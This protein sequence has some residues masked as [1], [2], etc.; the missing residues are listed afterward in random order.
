MLPSAFILLAF[1]WAPLVSATPVGSPIHVPITRR[2]PQLSRRDGGEVNPL[3]R[4]VKAADFVRLK[5]GFDPLSSK[6][7][8]QNTA[9]VPIIDQNSDSSYLG[10]I[11]IGTPAQTFNVILDTGS[12]DFWLAST[13]CSTCPSG[14]PEYSSSKSS[15]STLSTT[16]VSIKYGSGAVAGTLTQDAL[17]MGGFLVSQQQFVSVTQVSSQFLTGTAAGLMGLGWQT[18]ASSGAMPFWQALFNANQFTTPEFS[19]YLRRLVDDPSAP[20]ETYGGEFTLGGTNSSLY[21]G[22]IEFLNFP[23]GVTPSFWVLPVTGL[24]V[25]GKA[26]T[27][28][29]GNSALAA[30]DTGTTLIGGPSAG[31]QAYWAG[32]PGSQALTGQYQGFYAFPCST[33]LTTTISFGGKSWPVS[34]ADMNLG[35]VSSTMCM[36]GIFDLSL[37]SSAGSGGGPSW[38]VGDTFLKNVYSVFRANPPSVGFAQLSS[39]AGGSGPGSTSIP[40][41]VAI[42]ISGT[43][44]RPSS[45]GSSGGSNPFASGAAGLKVPNFAWAM[46]GSALAG[47]LGMRLVL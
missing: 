36:G 32:V 34:S 4:F 35:Q 44:A 33:T 39:A 11:S 42:S 40:S 41:S 23:S 14:T 31:V 3:D 46:L 13:G 45:T 37:G 27:V 16:P 24:T 9:E 5:Y 17:N 15:T 8:R 38:V 1:L 47:L 18:I 21:T 28:P 10:S 22:N 29:T 30:I 6:R 7:K 26:V 19:F 20:V 2:T 43:G 12:A 25:G